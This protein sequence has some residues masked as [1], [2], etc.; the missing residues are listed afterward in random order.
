MTD[1]AGL[2]QCCADVDDRRH[3]ASS[4]KTRRQLLVGLDAILQRHDQGVG[5]DGRREII[6]NAGHLMG[7]YA[8]QRQ[9]NA[10][11]C[12]GAGDRRH[13][14]QVDV[15]EHVRPNRETVAPQRIE[16]CTA[17]DE[18]HVRTGTRQQP[19]EESADTAGAIHE[20]L[21]RI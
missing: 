6:E 5:P 7:L 13:P 10:S 1:D 21:H 3:D 17:R 15:A 18:V 20:N 14:R 4:A 9:I 8:D 12:R 11:Q 16:M 2:L 19:A